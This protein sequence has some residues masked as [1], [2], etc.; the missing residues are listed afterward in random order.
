MHGVRCPV[1]ATHRLPLMTTDDESDLVRR[2]YDAL[3][4]HYRR[5]DAAE[6]RYAPWIVDL[7]ARLP[8]AGAVLDLGC[9]C[10]VPVARSLAAAGYPVTGVDI[11]EAGLA[12]CDRSPALRGAAR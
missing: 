6:G 9:G 10:G 12:D 7:K 11:S 1:L 3:S 4:Y 5:N 2:G 8:A